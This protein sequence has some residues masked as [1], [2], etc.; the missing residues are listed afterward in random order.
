[1]IARSEL[2]TPTPDVTPDLHGKTKN[3]AEILAVTVPVAAEPPL[4]LVVEDEEIVGHLLVFLLTREGFKVEW[5]K[6][7]RDADHFIHHNNA[8]TLVLLDINLPDID[9]YGLLSLIRARASW[10]QTPVI[11]LTAMSEASDVARAVALGADNYL[12]KP[13]HPEE[14]IRRVYKLCR[15]QWS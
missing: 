8:P 6:N 13:F 7:G 3:Q 4:V 15:V 9:G 10:Q 5:K 14:L 11:M 2:V 1:M 12:L